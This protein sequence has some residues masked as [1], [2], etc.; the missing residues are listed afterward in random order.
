MFEYSI[1][2]FSLLLDLVNVP[3][4]EDLIPEENPSLTSRI[5]ELE[6]KAENG[7]RSL[8]SIC[9]VIEISKEGIPNECYAEETEE[10]QGKKDLESRL[11]ILESRVARVGNFFLSI[12]GTLENIGSN[13]ESYDSNEL[14]CCVNSED[15][16]LVCFS[17]YH[18]D[19]SFD[20]NMSLDTSEIGTC[21]ISDTNNSLC[22]HHKSDT[23]LDTT[24]LEFRVTGKLLLD[25]LRQPP[26]NIPAYMRYNLES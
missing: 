9:N 8:T 23:I 6:V 1:F 13:S 10:Y 18:Y 22:S 15:N 21:D 24:D 5:I 4:D 25:D 7:L 17:R 19:D 20:S 11:D 3:D 14:H 26:K 2:K 12:C 16:K